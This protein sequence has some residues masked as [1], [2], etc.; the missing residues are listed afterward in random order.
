MNKIK[1]FETFKIKDF[2]AKN[3]NELYFNTENKEIG[4]GTYGF[5]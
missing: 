5:N 4:S 3:V 1:I 2:Q